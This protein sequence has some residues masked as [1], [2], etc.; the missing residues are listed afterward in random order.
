VTFDVP[1]RHSSLSRIQF[2]ATNTRGV[3]EFLDRG[4]HG[5]SDASL[6]GKDGQ[7]LWQYGGMPGL[8]DMAA[9]DLDGDG[10]PEFVAGFNG[11]GGLRCLDDNAHEQWRKPGGNL[12]HVEIVDTNGDGKPEIIHTS[13]QGGFTIRDRQGKFLRD[14]F[15]GGDG[16]RILRPYCSTF[17]LCP[18]PDAKGPIKIL[19]VAGTLFNS[20]IVVC[21]FDGKVEGRY[22][23]PGVDKIRSAYGTALRWEKGEPPLLAVIGSDNLETMTMLVVFKA[24]GE[25]VFQETA[26]G[27]GGALLA[28]PAGNSGIDDLLVGRTNTVERYSFAKR[29]AP[30]S[31]PK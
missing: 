28:V 21:D 9:G 5:W 22:S 15:P 6:Y 29:P 17:S 18:W 8:D 16:P 4:G 20:Q 24:K 7:L 23:F 13:N 25:I 3:W 1:D 30:P 2:V 31:S 12:W 27:A 19:T 14:V 10:R 26:P 11:A